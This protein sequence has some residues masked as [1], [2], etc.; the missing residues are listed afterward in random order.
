MPNMSKSQKNFLKQLQSEA[1]LQSKLANDYF[2][3]KF[4]SPVN[5]WILT[6]PWQFVLGVSLILAMITC[7]LV[8][9]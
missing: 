8:N 4:L 9:K 6:Y 3:P 5:E 2:L 7:T 1:V